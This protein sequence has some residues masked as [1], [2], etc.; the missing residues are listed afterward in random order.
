M[1]APKTV[2][3]VAVTPIMLKNKEYVSV[4]ERSRAAHES[5]DYTPGYQIIDERFFELNDR[6]FVTVTI[7]VKGYRHM[8]TSE[9]KF[10]ADPKS[11][12]GT[13]PIE[14]AETSAVGRALGFAGFG[15]V[16]SIASAD[17]MRRVAPA[18]P[19]SQ[20]TSKP[21]RASTTVPTLL[22]GPS[23]DEVMASLKL[24][25]E[26]LGVSGA[27]L[28]AYCKAHQFKAGD[29]GHMTVLLDR[30]ALH[31]IQTELQAM[32]WAGA[33]HLAAVRSLMAQN[34]LS[35]YAALME[36]VA[37]N[38]EDWQAALDEAITSERKEAMA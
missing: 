1:S 32:E 16:D 28:H 7:E 33:D 6:Y 8:G 11:A 15:A 13:N 18:T 5:P 27:T 30:L 2:Q 3:G 38:R 35:D 37:R 29:L 24:R 14:C 9:I 23:L 10:K 22:K 36:A 26:D 34:N 19:A 17:E 4:A 21:A 31:G 20:S 25:C 12:D